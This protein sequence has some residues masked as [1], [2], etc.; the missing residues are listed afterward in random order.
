[1]NLTPTTDLVII[2]TG[3]AGLSAA[4]AAA[5]RGASVRVVT[6]G[7]PL[8]GSSHW[9][10]G[11]IAAAVGPDDS[12]G[13]H[14][15]DTE[16][17]GV[18]LNDPE[19][20]RLLV[21]LGRDTVLDLWREGVPFAGGPDGP[22]LALEA[23][24]SRR[25]VLHAIGGATGEMLSAALLARADAHPLIEVVHHAPVT[26]LILKNERVV[27][28]S[29][30]KGDFIGN[31]TVLATGG[32]AALWGRTTN[33]L[34]N[35]GSGHY[36]AWQAGASLVDLEFVQFH[37][38]ALDMPGRPAYL[39][40]EAL[41]GEGALLLDSH[42]REIIDPLLPRDIVARAISRHLREHGPVYL[43]MRHLDPNFVRQHFS[44]ITEHLREWNLDL[45]TDPIPVA[46][47]AHYCMG[48][49]YTDNCGYTGVPGLYA[50]GEVACTGAQGANRL[51][52]NSML[53]CLVYGE[54]AAI[55]ALERP[56]ITGQE[57]GS[58]EYAPDFRYP[59]PGPSSPSRITPPHTQP[60]VHERLASSPQSLEGRLDRDLGV[61]RNAAALQA[62]IADLP[63]PDA[64]GIEP[65][66]LLATLTARAALMREES[67][68][69]HYRTDAPSTRPEWQG[70][71]FWQR[72][73]SPRFQ[74]L[75]RLNDEGRMT[76]NEGLVT[77]DSYKEA[78][79]PATHS[80]FVI[81]PSSQ[82]G[83][84]R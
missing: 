16:R 23:G 60:P 65:D 44:A 54:R 49:V 55:A 64:P 7:A 81:R 57:A 53:E 77:A 24:H 17:V 18:G 33:P 38:T 5:N 80:S 70:R 40:S 28:A 15:S 1:M 21:E 82:T 31:A 42:D 30:H 6:A 2:G 68:G 62:L 74:P 76:N 12:P 11:G 14:A 59:V 71:I 84:S 3:L 9:A 39:L 63:S 52:S 32:Y 83:A 35:R 50:A 58:D 79:L 26:R 20:V 73:T 25:R 4:L 10:Q 19:A 61:E 67:R 69:A 37:P 46:P 75:A 36:L 29:T 72:D 34:G 48:G 27:G 51:A 8:S 41:R 78:L 45:A 22:D 43:S 66:H 56:G 13:L 47:A